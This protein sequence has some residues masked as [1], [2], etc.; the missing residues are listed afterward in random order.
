MPP[1]TVVVGVGA[2]LQVSRHRKTNKA[3]NQ[4]DE[5]LTSCAGL[6]QCNCDPHATENKAGRL[7]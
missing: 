7:V 3:T 4:G 5:A 6:Q 2:Q 1:G